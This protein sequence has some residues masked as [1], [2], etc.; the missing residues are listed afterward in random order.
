[1]TPVLFS[2]ACSRSRTRT[3]FL[4]VQEGPRLCGR[5]FLETAG[6]CI[7]I[8]L[9]CQRERVA[10]TRIY[11]HRSKKASF[12]ILPSCPWTSISQTA[13]VLPQ[14]IQGHEPVSSRPASWRSC[15]SLSGSRAPR[16]HMTHRDCCI[17]ISVAS[18]QRNEQL[19][20]TAAAFLTPQCKYAFE[21]QHVTQFA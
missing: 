18:A 17:I 14:T 5:E 19:N 2:D 15:L 6:T 8:P 21:R 1:M 4:L 16:H 7:E 9:A 13:A 20:R 3:I 10:S 11:W 12:D